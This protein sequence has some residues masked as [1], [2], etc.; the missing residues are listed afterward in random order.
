MFKAI[1]VVLKSLVAALSVGKALLEL[2][3]IVHPLL[4]IVKDD[5]DG[6]GGT[7]PSPPSS[8]PDLSTPVEPKSLSWHL[9]KAR[10]HA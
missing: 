5:N 7:D 1:N 8:I 10:G 9:H 4:G 6:D 3:D 2:K